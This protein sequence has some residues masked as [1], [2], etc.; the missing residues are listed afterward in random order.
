MTDPGAVPHL[1]VHFLAHEPERTPSSGNPC[2]TGEPHE[3]VEFL[4]HNVDP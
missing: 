4:L 2:G 1:K 3:P